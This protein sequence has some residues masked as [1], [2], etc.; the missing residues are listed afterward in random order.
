MIVLMT[1]P[2]IGTAMPGVVCSL[3]LSARSHTALFRENLM[4]VDMHA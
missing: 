3:Q 1:R 4:A 2:G